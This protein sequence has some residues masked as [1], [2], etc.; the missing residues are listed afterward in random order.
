MALQ[1]RFPRPDYYLVLTA[2]LA[3]AWSQFKDDGEPW[4]LEDYL[5]V[6]AGG[7]LLTGVFAR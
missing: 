6:L 1:F 4:Q 3:F 5:G 2:A 7:W